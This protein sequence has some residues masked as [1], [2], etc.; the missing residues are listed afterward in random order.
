MTA[1]LVLGAMPGWAI[2]VLVAGFL[3]M[4]V[5]LVLTV[6]IQRPQG[7]GLAG[8][9]GGAAGSGQTAFGAKTGDALTVATITMFAIYIL[10]A[11]GLNYALAPAA[12][13]ATTA[14]Q[15]TEQ[16]ADKNA[17]DATPNPV[18]LPGAAPSGST[19]TPPAHNA[20]SA[21]ISAAPTRAR[22]MC[23]RGLSAGSHG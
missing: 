6:L 14:A 1:T 3:L 18:P 10:L 16:P 21:P 5:L 4:C 15:S 12:A 17:P 11:I 23:R 9:F 20:R 7:G 8:A 22:P 13:P 2:G 19:T